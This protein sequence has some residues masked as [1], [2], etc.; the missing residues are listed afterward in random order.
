MPDIPVWPECDIHCVFCS[1]PVRGFR[2]TQEK[3]SFAQFEARWRDYRAGRRIFLKFDGRRDYCS[4]TGGEP[5]L[6][7]HFLRIL[8]LLRR[9]GPGRRIRLLTNCGTFA[10]EKFASACLR[11]GGAPL[12]VAVP[13]F[14]CDAAEHERISRCRGSFA[15]TMRGLDNVFRLR[16]PG[17]RVEAR[18]ILHGLQMPQLPRLLEFLPRR[19]PALDAVELLF[20]EIEGHAERNWK[21][22]RLSLSRCARELGALRDLLARLPEPRLLHFPLCILP[23]DLR[24][25]A[26]RTLD[27]IKVDFPPACGKC[28]LR[29]DCVGVHVSYLQHMGHREFGPGKAVTR[30]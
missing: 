26:R 5:T 6:H 23:P 30:R 9:D 22:I 11:V 17:Q 15:R 16:G 12:E 13:L 18:I 24:P 1:N 2:G 19:F 7:P 27:P 25:Y 20:V 10:C 3:Y 29:P 4:L 21:D 14:G 28:R 8:R